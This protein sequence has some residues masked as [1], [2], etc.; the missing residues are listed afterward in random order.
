MLLAL[1]LLHLTC[2]EGYKEQVGFPG[3]GAEEFVLLNIP[4]PW[5][6]LFGATH[7]RFENCSSL[8]GS[9]FYIQ[10]STY[11]KCRG[12]QNTLNTINKSWALGQMPGF[13]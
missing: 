9:R 2:S 11:R 10:L 12:L 5:L 13:H 8:M 6:E 3:S 4:N 1:Q 7:I